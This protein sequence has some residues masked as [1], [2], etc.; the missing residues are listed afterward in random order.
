M[1][2]KKVSSN[3]KPVLKFRLIIAG[4]AILAL[5]IS[6]PLISVW[7][8]VYINDVSLKVDRLSK[9]LTSINSQIAELTIEYERLAG[10]ERIEKLAKQ[11]LQLDFPSSS[12][13]AI[14]KIKGESKDKW[15]DKPKELFALLRK[16]FTGDKG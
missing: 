11:K 14:V 1:R 12:Q 15:S 7:K 8:Q 13:I 6:G 4:V 10:I 2:K 5:L 16:T 3:V 9:S